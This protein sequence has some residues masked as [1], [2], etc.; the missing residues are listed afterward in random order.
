MV[1]T[2]GT[3]CI[4]A[5]T[6]TEGIIEVRNVEF[7]NEDENLSAGSGQ[8]LTLKC[9]VKGNGEVTLRLDD[10]D[11]ADIATV[12]SMGEAWEELSAE[13]KTA[14]NGTHT[15]YLILKGDVQLDTW[16]MVNGA[17]AIGQIKN[18]AS[19]NGL[20]FYNLQGQQLSQPTTGVT[21]VCSNQNSDSKTIFRK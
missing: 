11:G 7:T 1:A 6:P 2:V 16:Q 20:K 3:T 13:V 10:K 8:A 14:L 19:L 9:R 4:T 17:S 15:I 5:D 21:I 12:S 18:E